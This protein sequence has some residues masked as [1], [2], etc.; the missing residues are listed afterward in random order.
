M[1]QATKATKTKKETTALGFSVERDT[2]KEAL[3]ITSKAISTSSTLPILACVLLDVNK[4]KAILSATNLAVSIQHTIEIESDSLFSCAIPVKAFSGI[5]SALPQGRIVFRY[6]QDTNKLNLSCGSAKYEFL[7]QSADD[8]PPFP[9]LKKS[10]ECTLDQVSLKGMINTVGHAASSDQSSR[11]VICGLHFIGDGKKLKADATDG[12]R[13]ARI[14]IP[15]EISQKVEF[16]LPVESGNILKS[17]LS[18]GKVVCQITEEKII[19]G[20]ANTRI[21]S[22]L[23]VGAFPNVEQVIPKEQSFT[24]QIKRMTLLDVLNRLACIKPD[25]LPAV[26]LSFAE[27]NSVHLSLVNVNWGNGQ[28]DIPTTHAGN[29]LCLSLDIG[30]LQEALAVLDSD[31][32][33]FG[34]TDELSPVTIKSGEFLE[35]IMPLRMG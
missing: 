8:F 19:F 35:V 12:R 6:S 20:L 15:T 4:N 10:V 16:T 25:V 3:S 30:Y 7:C 31:E 2:L 29:K 11:P 5:V 27:N 17:L 9:D 1:K 24:S 18:E 32:I 13:L 22:S 21:S 23:I 34:A 33:E 28:E 14:S 26:K